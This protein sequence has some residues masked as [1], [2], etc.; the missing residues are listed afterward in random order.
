MVELRARWNSYWLRLLAAAAAA[1][2]VILLGLALAPPA[3]AGQLI[4]CNQVVIP[5]QFCQGW[6]N[7]SFYRN[8]ANYWGNGHLQVC[9]QAQVGLNIVS[10]KCND[11]HV[12]SQYLGVANR[13]YCL[14]SGYNKHTLKCKVRFL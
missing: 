1:C 6:A 13:G 10:F 14:N 4:Y 7:R 9:E 12:H 2:A 5:N 11:R 3:S 8:Y